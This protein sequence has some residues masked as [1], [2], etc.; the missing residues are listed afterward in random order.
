MNTAQSQPGFF[1]NVSAYFDQAASFTQQPKGLLD[2]IKVCNSV[3][4]F[5]FPLRTREGYEVIS[6]WRAQHS[7]RCQ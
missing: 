6:G 4:S 5:K 3:Y 2:Q 1:D 7:H